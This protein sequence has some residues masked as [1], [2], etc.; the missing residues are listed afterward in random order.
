MV[1]RLG[2]RSAILGKCIDY[3]SH[4]P[5]FQLI[6]NIWY[7]LLFIVCLNGNN[8]YTKLGVSTPTVNSAGTVEVEAAWMVL[9]ASSNVILE[10]VGEN[11]RAAT[12]RVES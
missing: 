11:W 6:Y 7:L 5:K 12:Y 4:Q 1:W 10:L 3:D 2:D 8:I 9:F